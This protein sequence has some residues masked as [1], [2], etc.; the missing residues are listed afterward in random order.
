METSA[1]T[2]EKSVG[3]SSKKLKSE[4][5]YDQAVLLLGIYLVI[6]LNWKGRDG[7]DGVVGGRSKKEGLYVCI[8]LIH[9]IVQQKLT[10][11]CKAIM[12]LLLLSCFSRVRLCVTP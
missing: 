8:Y 11:H 2:M 4:L 1:A 3:G 12:L 9:F 10:K 5:P 7:W 6:Y